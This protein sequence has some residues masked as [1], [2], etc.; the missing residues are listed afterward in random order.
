MTVAEHAR[1]AVRADIDRLRRRYGPFRRLDRRDARRRPRLRGRPPRR[2]GR[3]LRPI[4]TRR[5]TGGRR[6]ARR[7]RRPRDARGGGVEVVIDGVLAAHVDTVVPAGSGEATRP[8][9][10]GTVARR[11]AVATRQA[12]VTPRTAA[13]ASRPPGSRGRRPAIRRWPGWSWCS[14][15]ATRGTTPDRNPERSATSAGSRR[16]RRPTLSGTPPW[17]TPSNSPSGARQRG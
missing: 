1:A 7:G 13:N 11:Q 6:V 4:R 3:R 8:T 5:Q 16:R 10:P 14:T 17:R 15:P 2:A 9:R 12:L